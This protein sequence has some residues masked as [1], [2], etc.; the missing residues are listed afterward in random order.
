MPFIDSND[1]FTTFATS[2]PK[3]LG[4]ISNGVPTYGLF[5]Y[6]MFLDDL[7]YNSWMTLAQTGSM[8]LTAGLILTAAGTRVFFIPITIYGQIVGHKTK[9]L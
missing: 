4:N 8:G 7:F 6:V 2:I 1:T 3:D 5:E 9:L